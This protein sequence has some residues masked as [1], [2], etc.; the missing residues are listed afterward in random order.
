MQNFLYI[1]EKFQKKNHKKYKFLN[2][3][4]LEKTF[5]EE[6]YNTLEPLD[7]KVLATIIQRQKL[8]IRYG[9]NAIHPYLSSIQLLAERLIYC[10]S[11]DSEW[12]IQSRGEKE[13]ASIMKHLMI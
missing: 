8:Y 3:I 4:N 7:F 12:I 10:D 13:D 2:D 9:E 6:L 1:L 5:H 11:K